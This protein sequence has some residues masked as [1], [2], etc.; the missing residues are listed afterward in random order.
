MTN[1]TSSLRADVYKEQR[2]GI[3]FPDLIGACKRGNVTP[4]GVEPAKAG[5]A[6][7]Y[8][9]VDAEITVYV[10]SLGDDAHKT[11]AD[12]LADA[13][14]G[15]KALEAKGEYANVKIYGFSPDKEKRGWK[16]AAFTSSSTNRYLV[17]FVYCKVTPEFFVKIRATTGNPKNDLLQA[18]VKE[19]QELVD[20][21]WK[22]P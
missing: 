12:L 14:A 17:S 18:F 9:A 2:S 11:S 22:K 19:L 13:L 3:E 8:E 20:R 15:V 6:I 5:V 10:R 7:Q 4:Y 1:L 16:S 21:E